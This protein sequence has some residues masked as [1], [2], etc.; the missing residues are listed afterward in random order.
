MFRSSR[1]IVLTLLGSAAMLGCCC[2]S[3]VQPHREPVRDANGNEVR[4]ANGQVV[5]HHHYYY[6]PWFWYGG[7]NS[8]GWPFYHGSYS[9]YSPSG[10]VV[11]GGTGVGS[12]AG[13]TSRGG[14]GSTGHATAGS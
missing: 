9:S 1:N 2:T 4:D 12:T 6:H 3:C 10:R 8:Y 14:F 11:G 5:Y 13:T 7:Y